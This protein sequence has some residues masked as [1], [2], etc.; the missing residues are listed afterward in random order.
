MQGLGW[1]FLCGLIVGVWFGVTWEPQLSG[2]SAELY[3]SNH[4]ASA[5]Y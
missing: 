3:R 2:V 5:S 1:A 4:S